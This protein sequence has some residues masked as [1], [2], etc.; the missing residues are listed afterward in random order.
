MVAS[1]KNRL[2]VLIFFDIGGSM[3]DHIR[4]CEELFSAA[5]HE[6]KHLEYFYFHNCLFESV[7]KDNLRRYADRT[8]TWE[9]FNKFNRDYRVIIVGDASMSPYEIVSAGGSVEHF[10]EEP[11]MLWLQRLR[12]QF[13]KTVW[14]N[15]VP[16]PYW[17]YT[18]SIGMVNELME[19]K[20]FPL[21][22][23]GL[24]RAMKELRA[25]GRVRQSG[26]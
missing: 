6:F 25:P 22:L 9:L 2:K 8:P 3:D 7:W 5:R 10:N 17:K 21:T 12:S 15:P 26:I 20:M 13:P 19:S 16:E 1:R 18:Q 4:E 24:G 11:G 23:D 14:L